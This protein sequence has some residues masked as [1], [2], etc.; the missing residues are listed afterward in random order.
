MQ[1]A[2]LPT[3]VTQLSTTTVLP[4]AIPPFVVIW[5]PISFS[6]MLF[7]KEYN[8]DVRRMIFSV[9]LQMENEN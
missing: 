2:S 7:E 5:Q 4:Q 9:F 1:Q 3:G 8:V 6:G